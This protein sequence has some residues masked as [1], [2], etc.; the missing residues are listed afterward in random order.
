MRELGYGKTTALADLSKREYPLIWYQLMEEDSDPLVF[1]LHLCHATFRALPDLKNLPIALLESWDGTSS[2]LPSTRILDQWLNSLNS[3]LKGPVLLVL[4]DAHQAASA[5]EIAFLLDRMI[6]LAPN[7]L[8]I[9]IAGRQNL[10]IPNLARWKAQGMVLNIDRNVLA[11]TPSEIS[12]LFSDVYGYVLSNDEAELLFNA[13]EG[14]AIALQLVWQSLR[15]GAFASIEEVLSN[16][17]TTLDS[18]FQILATEIFEGQPDDVQ[19]FLR[20]TSI[21]RVITPSA[22]RALNI[23]NDVQAMLAYLKRIELFVVDLGDGSLRYHH[24]FRSF[25]EQLTS[26][27]QSCSSHLMAGAYFQE[28]GELD[29]AIYHYSRAGEREAT[30][31]L[32]DDYGTQLL[33]SGRLDTLAAYLNNLQPEIL[34]A[35]PTLLFYMGELAR[36]RSRFQEALGWY[37]QA[38]AAWRERANS[39]GISRALRGQARVYLD[40]VDPS[41]AEELLE[42][43][44][45][46]SDGLESQEMH[47]RL[48]ELLAENKLNS[49]QIEEAEKL[50]KQAEALRSQNPSDS[51]AA[52]PGAVTHRQAVSGAPHAGGP[53]RNRAHRTGLDAAGSP[54]D[55][56]AAF[57]DL[58]L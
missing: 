57:P 52:H 19:D 33:S 11:F 54:R 48:Y 14:W 36:L 6:G 39:K 18:L 40:T 12:T 30:A 50:R 3:G 34:H 23:N 17:V 43:S 32:L 51:A 15:S 45:R 20:T 2:L 37:R 24:I 7:D 13:T 29:E 38:E 21:L 26:Q 1:L 55:K 16:P 10:S 49:G 9:L 8:H 44:I 28:H 56:T 47:A 35:H 58:C 31:S 41:K 46:L 25:L 5:S 22:C 4:D 42:K 53:G 27:S